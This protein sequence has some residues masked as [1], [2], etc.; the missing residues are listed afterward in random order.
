M[1]KW[2]ELSLANAVRKF[3][4]KISKEAK[5]AFLSAFIIGFFT[6]CY[7][8]FNLYLNHDGIDNMFAYKDMTASGRWL[9]KA[10]CALSGGPCL[11]LVIG[12]LSI[13][14]LSVACALITSMFK[15][16]SKGYIVLL[17]AL[18]ATFPVVTQTFTYMF[19]A[20]G[21]MLSFL[22][23]VAAV[24]ITRKYRFG[25]LQA[26]ALVCLSLGIYQ[27]SVSVCIVLFSLLIAVDILDGGKTKDVFVGILKYISCGAVGCGLYFAVLKAVLAVKNISLSAYQGIGDM[28]PGLSTLKSSAA[29]AV[30]EILA[31]LFK[32]GDNGFGGTTAL[33]ILLSVFAVLVSMTVIIRAVSAKV[34]KR[35]VLFLL[36]PVLFLSLPF[37]T[38]CILFV[39][40][41]TDYYAVMFMSFSIVFAA[42][43]VIF[44]RYMKVTS[45]VTFI[46]KYLTL[47]ISVFYVLHFIL[48][49]N[50]AYVEGSLVTRNT[51]ALMTQVVSDLYKI[52]GFEKKPV[53]FRCATVDQTTKRPYYMYG[54]Y[55]FVFLGYPDFDP[56]TGEK[57]FQ[58]L[59]VYMKLDYGIDCTPMTLKDYS[60]MVKE[61]GYRSI[62]NK[63]D[64]D[65]A[66]NIIEYEGKIVIWVNKPVD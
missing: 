40:P 59:T 5:L 47:G 60:K 10:V 15:V 17:S 28:S 48:C 6:H 41:K 3:Y 37:S 58:D 45:P 2:N 49:A 38:C 14:Y 51:E 22:L 62:L 19:T 23:A 11:P 61:S 18:V 39:S 21:Y 9:L 50:Y 33:M 29:K 64:R 66:Y 4:L 55:R 34:Y 31:F 7:S 52:D 30:Q 12:I 43:P 32:F 8:F 13:F 25:F 65:A 16:K 36:L 46:H 56:D 57:V 63:R 20:D 27:A 26:S 42:V 35:P 44:D 53:A 24:F 54:R 1:V